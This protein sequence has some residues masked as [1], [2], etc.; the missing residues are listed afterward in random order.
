LDGWP[1]QSVAGSQRNC[2]STDAMPTDASRGRE[3]YTRRRNCEPASRTCSVISVSVSIPTRWSK[4]PLSVPYRPCTRRRRV[5]LI[6]RQFVTDSVSSTFS[7]SKT[8]YNY[9]STQRA[10]TSNN[11]K[12]CNKSDPTSNPDFR[13][14]PDADPDPDVRRI[15]PKMLWMH[16]LIGVSHFTK[17]GTNRPLIV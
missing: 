17:Y 8:N 13:I 3:S 7:F 15:C 14:N 4:S 6:G 12:I 11:A 16:Y 2:V 9:N 1:C 10:Q 5:V